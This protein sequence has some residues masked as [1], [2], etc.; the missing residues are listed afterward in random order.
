[1]RY[2][3]MNSPLMPVVEEIENLARLGFDFIELTLDAPEATPGKV[4]RHK[5]AICQVLS[6]YGLDIVGHLPTFVSTAD[7]YESI[8][9]ASLNEVL[10]AVEA[11]FELGM[12]KFVLHPGRVSGMGRFRKREATSF[13]LESLDTFMEKA[14]SL[15]AAVCLENMF[16]ESGAFVEAEEFREVLGRY[17]KLALTLDLAHAHMGSKTNRTYGF[18]KLF[19]DRI[20]HLHVSDN[21]GKED[22]HLPIGA[23]VIDFRPLLKEIREKGYDDTMTLEVFSRDRDYLKVSLEK[24]KRLWQE[25]G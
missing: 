24:V 19:G 18:L 23:G 9:A 11:G 17:P 16:P 2:G 21:F 5:G 20:G 14:E 6:D 13:F 1:M 12:R 3:A 7:L 22:I 4:L 8:R 25:L 15:G 10:R